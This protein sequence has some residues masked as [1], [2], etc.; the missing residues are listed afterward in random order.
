[1]NTI[2]SI[3]NLSP[4]ASN[5]YMTSKIAVNLEMLRLTVN[6]AIFKAA[7]EYLDESGKK[8]LML[9]YLE[10][11]D[12]DAIASCFAELDK[13][14]SDFL[15]RSKQHV[16]ELAYTPQNQKLAEQL[17]DVDYITSY[18][19]RNKKKYDSATETELENNVILCRVKATK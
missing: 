10:L 3:S 2:D 1:M 5:E 18:T 11:L 15:D 6:L 7:W 14:Y 12:A 13:T 16:A 19:L 4:T 9:E 8:K 17:K